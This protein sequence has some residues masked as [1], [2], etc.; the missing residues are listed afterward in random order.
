LAAI[1]ALAA[2]GIPTAVS[3]APVIPALTD[4][5]MER[6]LEA[7]ATHGASA[8][9]WGLL[10]L[11]HDIKDL[12]EQWLARHTPERR[13]HVLNQIREYRQGKL[14]DSTFGRRFT[15]D[16]PLSALLDKRFQIAL[17]RLGLNAKPPRLLRTDLFAVPPRPGDQ[18]SL[19]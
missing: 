10:R 4:H 13:T 12:F 1:R 7:A 8:A 19:F 17:R 15:G 18:L 2:A 3:V 9:S 5:E 6:I 16:G 11:S 14:N